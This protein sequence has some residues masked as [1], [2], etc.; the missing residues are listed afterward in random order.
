M[1]IA[2]PLPIYGTIYAILIGYAI[3]FLPAAFQSL[4]GSI[5]M[6]DRGLEEAA[7]ITGARPLRTMATI[8]APLAFP[9]VLSAF[10]LVLM[11]SVRDVS[12]GLFLNGRGAEVLGPSIYNFWNS[13]G[14][15][16]TCALVLVQAVIIGLA[17]AVA[18][19]ASRR[20]V[21]L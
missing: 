6:I 17:L 13:G 8:T 10:A 1:V 9:G 3:V 16:T 18:Q 4:Q 2:L 15:G 12:V 7:R 5:G 20:R 21:E 19:I 11:N 14:I